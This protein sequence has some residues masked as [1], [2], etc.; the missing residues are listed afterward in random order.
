M[1]LVLAI[2]KHDSSHFHKV[3]YEN[4]GHY[5]GIIFKRSKVFKRRITFAGVL[6]A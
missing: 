3:E 1:T 6:V 4:K 5:F 2:Y